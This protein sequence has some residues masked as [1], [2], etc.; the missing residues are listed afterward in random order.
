MW[1]S[2][3]ILGAQPPG[4]ERAAVMT[5]AKFLVDSLRLVTA[6]GPVHAPAS[7]DCPWTAPGL[8]LRGSLGESVLAGNAIRTYWQ[9]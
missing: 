1:G 6:G 7:R 3:L 5:S 9:R 4:S 8:D 2:D